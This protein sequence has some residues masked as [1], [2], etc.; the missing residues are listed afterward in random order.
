MIGKTNV[1]GGGGGRATVIINAPKNSWV[2]YSG[3]ESGTL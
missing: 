1:G 2:V 3:T